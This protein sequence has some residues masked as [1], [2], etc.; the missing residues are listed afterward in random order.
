MIKKYKMCD[1][2]NYERIFLLY[3]NSICLCVCFNL[4][5]I[6]TFRLDFPQVCYLYIYIHLF[7]KQIVFPLS[8]DVDIFD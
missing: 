5:T 6:N 1:L 7:I 4:K 2:I 3:I 8:Q